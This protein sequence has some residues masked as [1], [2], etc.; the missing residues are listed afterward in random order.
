MFERFINRP[1]LATVISV[2]IVLLGLIGIT[3]LPLTQFPDI[4]PPSVE[5]SASYPGANAETIARSVAPALEEAIN[6]VDDM[7]YMTS[8]SSNDGSLAINVFFRQGTDPDQAAVNVQNRVA[9]ATSKLPEEVTKIGVSTSK[10]QNSMIMLISLLS[11]DPDTYDSTF[12]QNY[13]KINLLPEIQR[14]DGV[15]QAS[16]F[17]SKDYAMR[18]WLDPATMASYNLSPQEV[19]AAVQ[20]QNVE[21]APGRFG[22]GSE[23]ALELI[24]RYKGK[25]KTPEE[26]GNIIIRSNEDGS[27]LRLDDVA[28]VELGSYSYAVNAEA[29]GKASV[30]MA[31]YQAAGS[32]SNDIQVAL[33]EVLDN[34]SASFP[35]GVSYL[36]PY[37]T[38]ES[39]DK[40]IEQ[41]LHTL[42]EAFLLV[43]LVVFIFLQDFRSTLIPALAV[44]VALVGTFFFMTLFGFSINLLTLFALVLAIGIVVDDAIVI[45]EAVHAKMEQ[46]HQPANRATHHVMREIT[47][48]IVSITLVMSSVFLPVGFL[49][50]STGIFFQQFAFT[51]AIAILISALN[52]LTLS[53]ALCALL[54]TDKHASEGGEKVGWLRGV[55]LRLFKGFNA[56][57]SAL[58]E[59]YSRVAGLLIRRKWLS[60]G[61]LGVV[62]GLAFWMSMVTPSG[63][64]PNEDNGFFIMN[65]TLPPG[66]SLERTTETLDNAG[67]LLREDESVETVITVA[68]IDLISGSSS[69][70]AGL[71]FVSLEDAEERGSVK[72]IGAVMGKLTGKVSALTEA[73]FFP[74]QPPTVPGFSNVGGLE[75]VLQD[76]TGGELGQLSE[77][78]QG[79]IGALMQRPEIASAFTMFATGYPQWEI[80]VNEERA[81]Q[82]GVDVENLLTVMQVYYGSVQ[83]SD[84]NRFGK[85]Y[86]VVM[87]AEPDARMDPSSLGEVFVK[88]DTGEMVPMNSLVSLKRVYGPQTVDHF[89]LFN[90]LTVNA[91]VAQGFSTGQAIDAVREVAAT[92]LPPGYSYDWDGVSREEVESGGQSVYIFILS[93]V[94]VYLLLSAQYES[95]LLPLAVIMSIPAGVLGVFFG[96]MAAGLENNIY[97]QIAMIMLIGLLGKNAILIVEYAIQRRRAGMG[98][99]ES[100]IEGSKA[101]F[102]PILMTSLAFT[103]GLLPLLKATG[104]SAIGNH[105]IGAAAVG[106]MVSGTVLGVLIIPVLYVVFQSLQE[107]ISGPAHDPDAEVPEITHE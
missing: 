78:S 48:A 38:K 1:V 62:S 34:S 26:Y 12:L 14:V 22:E 2:F 8:T 39:L 55:E 61:G 105:S 43:F 97:V 79:F 63:F 41:V 28:R 74:I 68:G 99:V 35:E 72:E 107:R 65:A 106:G 71:I 89:N 45:V 24:M 54:L 46:T 58:T 44:P 17:G 18:I 91:N 93:L 80:E 85:Y 42:F 56:G 59:R 103:A 30:T 75:I 101:R 104:P 76:R 95:Y 82:L 102:R 6:G 70:S 86:R 11:D 16:V 27:L 33:K 21:A 69:P 3:Q 13:V 49:E 5:V 96:V 60:L 83:V 10:K 67:K 53:P 64:I 19:M 40:S 9:R 29:N 50:G 100:A 37:S 20:G 94:F 47:S 31:I 4:A 87:Q 57:F 66:A 90:S 25:L 15:G 36:V 77:V 32:N 81:S 73:T 23:S 98:L 52:A 92:A 88:N 84:F 51:L 7:T